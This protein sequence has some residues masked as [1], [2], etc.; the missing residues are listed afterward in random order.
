VD[1]RRFPQLSLRSEAQSGGCHGPRGDRRRV[2]ATSH[3]SLITD[4]PVRRAEPGG[5]TI[6]EL[7]IVLGLIIFLTV[8]AIPALNS[9][10]GADEVTNAANKIKGVLD[11]ARSYAQA[12]NTFVFVGFV[13]VDASVDS[14]VSPQVTTGA[15]PYGRVAMVAVA[16]KDGT[17]QVQYDSNSP[18][19]DWIT[20]YNN[21]PCCGGNLV[22]VGN[23]QVLENLHFLVD[24][25]SW[26][27]TAHPGSNMARYQ[28][29]N[30]TYTLGNSGSNSVTPFTWP[31][32]KSL[33]ADYK[34]RFDKVI[35]FD[36]R[37]VARIATATNADEVTDLMEI[38]FQQTRGTT[39]PPV[40]TNQDLG[41]QAV[42][43]I[44]AT[45]GAVR[46]YRP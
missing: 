36:P 23:L 10:K 39:V 41:T 25:G 16:S 1:L 42:I 29:S 18:A 40:P 32:G 8:M 34:Y 31:L 26:T 3:R 22:A 46:I 33:T 21:A 11:Q 35:N 7:I 45:N 4:N 15:T 44:D 14:S 9:R 6:L 24:F 2:L 38:D 43:Q 5:F 17:R 13:E 30:T 12:N 28:P 20:K 19:A 37:G 27:P